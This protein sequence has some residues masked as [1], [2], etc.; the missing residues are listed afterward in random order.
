M[1]KQRPEGSSQGNTKGGGGEKQR[2]AGGK[3]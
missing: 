1:E 3:K 2:K